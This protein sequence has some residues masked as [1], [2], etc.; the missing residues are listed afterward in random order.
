[1]SFGHKSWKFSILWNNIYLMWTVNS[2]PSPQTTWVSYELIGNTEGSITENN[3]F[4]TQFS[5][6]KISIA[7]MRGYPEL[8]AYSDRFLPY[9]VNYENPPGVWN[10]T[11]QFVSNIQRG[12][13]NLN[14]EG[15]VSL[16]RPLDPPIQCYFVQR[17]ES[18][19]FIYAIVLSNWDAIVGDIF[20]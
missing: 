7:S 16:V 4:C 6:P 5:I 13:Q 9:L 11:V 3:P 17:N 18:Q 8:N 10:S 1:M 2:I 14:W 20:K 19:C 15:Y 12:R